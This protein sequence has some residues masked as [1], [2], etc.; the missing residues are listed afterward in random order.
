MDWWVWLLIA[1][2][3]VYAGGFI[4][5]FAV[6]VTFLHMV[7]AELAFYRALVWPIFLT[8][9]WPHGTPLPMD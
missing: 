1:I 2:A 9:G 7:T 4:L 6:H 5:V 8:T 3:V